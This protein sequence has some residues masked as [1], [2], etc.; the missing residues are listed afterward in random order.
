M[1]KAKLN[2]DFLSAAEK[3]FSMIA[4]LF[5]LQVMTNSIV[6]TRTPYFTRR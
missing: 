4:V 5:R 3:V 6:V 1:K 2:I